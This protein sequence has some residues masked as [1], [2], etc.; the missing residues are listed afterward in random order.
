MTGTRKIIDFGF[1]PDHSPLHFVLSAS[2]SDISVETRF[3]WGDESEDPAQPEPKAWLDSYRWSRISEHVAHDFNRRLRAAGLRQARWKAKETLLAPHFGRELVLL[4]WAVED[5]DSTV[6]PSMCANWSGLAPEERWWLFTTVNAA[7]RQPQ[8][9][10]DSGWRKAIK[11]AFAE[12]PTFDAS[13]AAFLSEQLPQEDDGVP[14]GKRRAAKA[15][16]GQIQ[17]KLL[18]VDWSDADDAGDPETEP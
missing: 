9:G 2:K 3:K 8:Y 14:K 18:S 5:A 7:S 4:I 6:I 1:T 13:P 11:V 16:T 15:R 17:M 12:N 10:K